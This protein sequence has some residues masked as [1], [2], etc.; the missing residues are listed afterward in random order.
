MEP[1]SN[2]ITH[3]ANIVLNEV[4]NS[5]DTMCV[6]NNVRLGAQQFLIAANYI[7]FIQKSQ[8]TRDEK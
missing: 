3:I 1:N 8:I 2:D 6:V 7:A 5:N 4:P